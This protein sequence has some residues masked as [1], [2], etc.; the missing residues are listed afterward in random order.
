MTWAHGADERGS[1][2]VSS[3]FGIAIF[4]AFLLL[5]TQAL[6]HLYATS[7][8]TAVTFDLARQ[9]S[10]A[11]G[12]CPSPAEIRARLGRWGQSAVRA[13]CIRGVGGSTVVTVSGP[14]PAAAFGRFA[15]ALGVG[16]ADGGWVIERSATYRTEV[17]P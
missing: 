1:S 6:V 3:V 4:L 16:R 7:T 15:S 14:S 9:A 17:S 11:D 5:S 2:S 13:D 8:V 12:T 10:A